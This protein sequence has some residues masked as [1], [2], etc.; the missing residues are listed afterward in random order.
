M[1]NIK[2]PKTGIAIRFVQAWQPESLPT[3]SDI[4]YAFLIAVYDIRDCSFADKFS[5]ALAF[6]R[7]RFAHA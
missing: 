5:D 2:D 1:P 7:V 4:D 3:L 6:L